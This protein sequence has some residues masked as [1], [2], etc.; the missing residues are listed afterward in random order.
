VFLKLLGFLFQAKWGLNP[1]FL[2]IIFGAGLLQ[3]LLTAPGGIVVQLPKDL[4]NLGHLIAKLFN[5]G[6]AT[7]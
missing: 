5:R 4:R 7:A 6:G 2:L 1:N 3:V